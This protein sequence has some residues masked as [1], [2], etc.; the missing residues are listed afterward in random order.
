MK[1]IGPAYY[2]PNHIIRLEASA[3]PDSRGEWM[4]AIKVSTTDGQTRTEII[5][6]DETC[7]DKAD[8]INEAEE[9]IAARLMK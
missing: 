9:Y 3:V 6:E 1:P 5:E 2:N 7:T 4:P 8:A